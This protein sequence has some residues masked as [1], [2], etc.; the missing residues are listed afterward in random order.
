MRN[1]Q[2]RKSRLSC[3][4]Q[5][6]RIPSFLRGKYNCNHLTISHVEHFF[7]VKVSFLADAIS[8]CDCLV[9]ESTDAPGQVAYSKHHGTTGELSTL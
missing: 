9:S 4:T 7:Y 6:T 3:C 8:I 1:S 5:A 2:G